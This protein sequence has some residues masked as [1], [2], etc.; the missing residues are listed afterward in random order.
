VS[1]IIARADCGFATSALRFNDTHPVA[2]LK[3]AAL[4]EG[5]RLVTDELWLG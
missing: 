1:K 3:S 5:A 4:A 2:R